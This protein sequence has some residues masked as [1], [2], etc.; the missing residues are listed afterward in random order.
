MSSCAHTL[1]SD[2][3]TAFTS[4]EFSQFLNK[5]APTH[6]PASN[7]LVERSVQTFK[8]GMKKT[9]SG[10]WETKLARFLFAS[11]NTLQSTTGVSPAELI[12]GR[13]L[14]TVLDVMHPDI[15]RNVRDSQARQKDDHDSTAT[16]QR[17]FKVG[18]LVYTRND[19]SG[20]RWI[21]GKITRL[22]GTTDFVLLESG[23]E[24]QRHADQL[25]SRV[26]KD[27]LNPTGSTSIDSEKN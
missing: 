21:P 4:E 26:G 11:R 2:N 27:I 5:N 22:N 18:D 19:G 20:I 9:K 15:S 12:F 6:H 7:G 8:E 3:A 1:V 16:T 13:R 24:V 23:R 25:R 17:L 10:S 14:R